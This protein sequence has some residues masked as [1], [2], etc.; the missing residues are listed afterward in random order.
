[1]H[2]FS[3]IYKSLRRRPVRSGLTASG[4]AVAVTAVV[5]LVGI[6]RGFETELLKVYEQHGADLIV[7]R[8]GVAQRLTSSLDITLADQIARLPNVEQVVPGLMDVVSF[9]KFDLFG[10]TV[11]GWPA[12][13]SV[14]DQMQV[15][16]GR[17]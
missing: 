14:F 6:S 17:R 9:E 1:M 13:S 12:D 15:V 2:F 11:N 5:M 4:V 8:A 3:L 16:D 10:V 7:V